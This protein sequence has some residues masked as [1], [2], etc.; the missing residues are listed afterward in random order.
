MAA[1]AAASPGQ[2]FRDELI[3]TAVRLDPGFFFSCVCGCNHFT[4]MRVDLVI[5]TVKEGRVCAERDVLC[6]YVCLKERVCWLCWIMPCVY[7]IG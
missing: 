3:A 1:D 7:V 2:T 4:Y 5:L 6:V